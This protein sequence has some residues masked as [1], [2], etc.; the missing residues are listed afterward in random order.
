MIFNALSNSSS[1]D[2]TAQNGSWF[3]LLVT[4]IGTSIDAMIVGVSLAFLNVNIFITAAAIGAA[5]FVMSTI[6]MLAGRSVG[7]EFGRWAEVF[8][9]L[10]LIGFGSSILIQHL[11]AS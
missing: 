9:G 5:T 11:S 6:G 4:A 2:R 3:I 8:G 10:G 7:N 1:Q